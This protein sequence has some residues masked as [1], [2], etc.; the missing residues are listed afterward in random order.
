MDQ[1]EMARQTQRR[2]DKFD[3]ISQVSRPSHRQYI[4]TLENWVMVDM[5]K[6][7]GCIIK[8]LF[9]QSRMMVQ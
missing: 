8:T 1:E 9:L 7:A 2:T 5:K 3:H 6:F 4:T